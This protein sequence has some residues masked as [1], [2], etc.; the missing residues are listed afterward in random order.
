MNA[1]CFQHPMSFA[2]STCVECERPICTE[3]TQTVANRPVCTACVASIRTRVAAEIGGQAVISA[4]APRPSA[5]PVNVPQRS[6]SIPVNVPRSNAPVAPTAYGAPA[7]QPLGTPMQPLGD[8]A[9]YTPVAPQPLYSAPGAQPLQTPISEATQV[10]LYGQATPG[11][12]GQ[13]MYGQQPAANPPAYAPPGYAP[14]PLASQS[15][16]ASANVGLNITLAVVIGVVLIL[17]VGVGFGFG[18]I[19]M[20]R[21]IPFLSIFVGLIVGHAVKA[22]AGGTGPGIGVIGAVCSLLAILVSYG[23]IMLSVSGYMPSPISLLLMFYATWRGYRI[24][25]GESN[26]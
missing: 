8:S 3:C 14:R 23:V 16:P 11:Q 26:Y 1:P 21:T 17:V 9:A 2:T 25:A 13:P 19:A 12:S 4:A 6:S 22:A 20:G 15:T 18:A 7:A 24:G 10:P 5:I